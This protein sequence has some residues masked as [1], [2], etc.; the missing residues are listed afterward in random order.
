MIRLTPKSPSKGLKKTP[1]KRKPFKRKS[2]KHIS[3][4]Q[5]ADPNGNKTWIQTALLVDKIFSKQ[6]SPKRKAP[7]LDPL[8]ILFSEYIRKRA[9]KR[10]GGCERCLT[11]KFDMAKD[12]GTIFPAWQHLQNSHF[13]GRTDKATRFDEDN[14]AGLCGACHMYLEHHPHEHDAWFRRYLGDDK[15][16]LLLARNRQMGKPDKKML[17]I[18]YQQQIK[19]LDN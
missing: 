8:D 9:I 6:N 1:L 14:C 13:F 17:T 11:P 15:F 18:Y 5:G 10:C 7:K 16:E 2:P 19:L 3:T 12:D 4:L